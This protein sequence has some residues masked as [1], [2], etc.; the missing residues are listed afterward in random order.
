VK[1]FFIRSISG[2]V[3]AGLIIGSIFIGPY[4]FANVFLAFL[5]LGLM[6]FYAFSKTDES[7]TDTITY[8]TSGILLYILLILISWKMIPP[9]YWIFGVGIIFTVMI[10]QV[11]KNSKNPIKN[12]GIHFFSYIYL[13]IP[14]SL[15][16]FLFYTSF[17][18]N[19]KVIYML[20]GIFGITWINDTFAYITGSLIGR[21]KLIERVSPNKTW[22]GTIGGLLFGLLTAYLLFLIFPEMNLQEWLGFALITIVFGNFGDLFES[23]LKRSINIKESGW[24]IPGHGGVLDRIDSILFASPFV[25]LYVYFII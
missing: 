4:V 1:K 16:N 20:I 10:I 24:I 8:Y 23:L 14:L 17:Q 11:L 18:L 13:V 6:E 12:L 9:S 3:F 21:T 15:L 22:E 2:V 7:S 19:D 25:F 5:I